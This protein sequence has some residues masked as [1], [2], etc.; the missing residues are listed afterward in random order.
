VIVN[1]IYKSA[2][3]VRIGADVNAFGQVTDFFGGLIDDA[4]VY[5]R[6]LSASE[7]QAIYN[8]GGGTKLATGNASGVELDSNAVGNI[9]QGNF[10]GTNAAGTAALG[11]SQYGVALNSA[12]INSIL[13]NTISGNGS[14]GININ[15]NAT[16]N[17]TVSWYRADGNANDTLGTRACFKYL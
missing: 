1:Q 6:V 3:P 12:S 8:A 16:P 2:T 13:N 15:G 10:I 7:I 17:G 14:D 4:A 5:S 9:V 11:N